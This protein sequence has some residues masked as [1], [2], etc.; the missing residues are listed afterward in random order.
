MTLLVQLLLMGSGVTGVTTVMVV[1]ANAAKKQSPAAKRLKAKQRKLAGSRRRRARVAGRQRERDSR[2]LREYR[3]VPA[4]VERD[5]RPVNARDVA[6]YIVQRIGSVT[7]MKLNRLIYLC[8]AA[9][10]AEDGRPLFEDAIHATAAGPV[11]TTIF[12]EHAHQKTIDR[13]PDGR[14]DKLSPRAQSRIDEALKFCGKLNE[15]TLNEITCTGPWTK[16]RARVVNEKGDPEIGS[17][18]LAGVWKAFV[19]SIA[20]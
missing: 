16:A 13:V 10:V 6:A 20:A 11:P 19:R 8:Q 5:D 1:R 4:P 7:S 17:S 3:P 15:Q 9:S 18:E 12:K 14:I 2:T